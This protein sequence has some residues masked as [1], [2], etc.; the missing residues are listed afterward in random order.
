MIKVQDIA[1]VRFAAPDLDAMQRFL[2][3]FGLIVHAREGDVMYA[4][5]YNGGLRVVDLSG[6]LMG[7]LYRQGR[8]IAWFL[9]THHEAKIPNAPM[10]WG[11]QPHKGHIF[12]SDWNSGLWSVKLEPKDKQ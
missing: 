6:E 9:P 5:F 11:P 12:F 1:Y 2:E 7:D 10:V 4:A 8:E 3:D